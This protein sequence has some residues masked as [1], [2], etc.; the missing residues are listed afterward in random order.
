M[1]IGNNR[2]FHGS[3]FSYRHLF[4]QFLFLALTN[5]NGADLESGCESSC[6]GHVWVRQGDVALFA[7]AVR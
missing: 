6:E 5:M 3:G 2:V 7:A 4:L 1:V